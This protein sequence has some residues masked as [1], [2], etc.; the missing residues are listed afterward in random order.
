M[1]LEHLRRGHLT[2]RRHM[3]GEYA[4]VQVRRINCGKDDELV[5]V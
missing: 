2:E 4:Y 1:K 3:P 5:I